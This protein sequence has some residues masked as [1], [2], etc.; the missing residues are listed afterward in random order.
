MTSIARSLAG[1][2]WFLFRTVGVRM[3]VFAAL[4]LPI[5]GGISGFVEM[6]D[7]LS[8]PSAAVRMITAQQRTARIAPTTVAMR[9]NHYR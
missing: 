5:Y 9:M 7:E 3:I 1:I 4:G 6:L 2:T 8:A